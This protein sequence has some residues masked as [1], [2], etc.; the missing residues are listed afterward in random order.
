VGSAAE[1]GAYGA[2]TFDRRLAA[3]YGALSVLAL[4]CGGLGACHFDANY[5]EK[6]IAA[7]REGHET[8][9]GAS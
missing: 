2:Y 4:G 7:T 9:G 5:A 6:L 3:G 1:P 8:G